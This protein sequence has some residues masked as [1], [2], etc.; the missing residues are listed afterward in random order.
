MSAKK[1]FIALPSVV[2]AGK[3]W[4]VFLILALV[5][6]CAPMNSL[7]STR[8][9]EID[10]AAQDNQG[11]PDHKA[12]ARQYENLAEEMQTRTQEQKAILEHKLHSSHFGK[13]RKNAKSQTEFKIRQY[14]QAAQE[15]REKAAHHRSMAVEQA[16]HQTAAKPK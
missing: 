6:A 12:L 13:N 4:V 7:T 3:R 5:A 1:Y 14:E 2:L 15:Y 9:A 16:T 11:N 10:L 8:P